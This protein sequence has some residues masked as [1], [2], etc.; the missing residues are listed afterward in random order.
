MKRYI[1][2][3]P[4]IALTLSYDAYQNQYFVKYFKQDALL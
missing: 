1:I 3:D 2:L 4:A